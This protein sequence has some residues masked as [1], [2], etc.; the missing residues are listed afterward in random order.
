MKHKKDAKWVTLI[1]FENGRQV[2]VYEPL[3]KYQLNNKLQQGWKKI[4]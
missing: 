4:S 1:K 3:R 2:C